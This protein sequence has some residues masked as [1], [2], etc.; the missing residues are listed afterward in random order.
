MIVFKS[1][2]RLKSLQPLIVSKKI[3]IN[4]DNQQSFV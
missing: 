3:E 2:Q 1:N 4:I